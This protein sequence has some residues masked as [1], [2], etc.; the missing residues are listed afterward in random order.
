MPFIAMIAGAIFGGC[1]LGCAAGIFCWCRCDHLLGNYPEEDENVLRRPGSL[2]YGAACIPPAYCW[3]CPAEHVGAWMVLFIHKAGTIIL[4]STI[5][6]WFT[7]ITSVSQTNGFGM[8]D[9]LSRSDA[10]SWQMIG[11]CSGLDFQSFGLGQLAVRSGSGDRSG[12]KRK[13]CSNFRSALWLC[14]SSGERVRNYWGT[15]ATFFTPASGMYSFLVFNLL[16]APC[17][18]AIGAIKREM[19]NA[20]WTWFAIGYQTIF[21]YLVAFCVYQH[22][23]CCKRHR[24]FRYRYGSGSGSSSR[25]YLS[26]VPS[27]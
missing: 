4:L 20:K 12:G 25:I 6:I 26:A 7:V 14:G 24:F 9:D 19:N 18:A 15:L 2:R 5:V 13:R 10:A 23:L 27:L 11:L 1:A 3:Q 17:F 16:C 22:W 21:A 8:V